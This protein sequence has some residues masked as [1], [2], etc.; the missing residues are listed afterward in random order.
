M[1]KLRKHDYTL[2]G[3]DWDLSSLSLNET[4]IEELKRNPKATKI[5]LSNNM[6]TKL[7]VSLHQNYHFL[8]KLIID[9]KIYFFYN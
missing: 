2:D 6:L 4:P 5:D 8:I 9:N 1:S 7:D 3:S